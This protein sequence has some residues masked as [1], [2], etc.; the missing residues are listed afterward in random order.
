MI[1]A[2][3]GYIRHQDWGENTDREMQRALNDLR[4]K[5]MKRLLYDIR[6]NR[7]VRSTR[8][9]RCRTSSCRRAR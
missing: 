4:S 7:E 8:L 3:T 2:T 6:G 1:D 5:G 9:S